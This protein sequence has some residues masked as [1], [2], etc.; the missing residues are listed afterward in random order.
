MTA[1]AP[2]QVQPGSL[3]GLPGI[4]RALENKEA[5]DGI[6]ATL[7]QATSTP[8]N[9]M[10]PFK[11]T[12]V[13][14]GWEFQ[15]TFATTWTAGTQTLNT[16]PYFPY[17]IV[18][19][20]Q[21]TM[22]NQ[23]NSIVAQSGIDLA[24][25]QVIRPQR[26]TDYKNALYTNKDG[27]A[28]YTPQGL[29]PSA[30]NYTTASTSITMRM[31]VPGG[32]WFDAFYPL[33]GDGSILSGPVRAFV[34]P[35][36][37]AGTARIVQP[38]ITYN[39][40]LGTTLDNAPVVATGTLTTPATFTGSSTL[41]LKRRGWYQPQG[42]GDSPAIYNW[43]Y[44]RQAKPYSLSGLTTAYIP[45]P[46]NGQILSIFVRLF[47]PTLASNIGGPIPLA[48]V[49]E[50]DVIYGSGL[51]RF[52]DRPVDMQARFIAQHGTL[53]TNGVLAWDMA[54]DDFGRVTNAFALNTMNTSGVQVVLTFTGAQSSS[55]YAVV[56]VEALTYVEVG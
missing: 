54:L 42:V 13:I 7:A 1:A 56:G 38:Q 33:S 9:G 10:V 49:S 17:N 21:L 44:T 18:G 30:G 36:Y 28:M 6:T 8:Q 47:D 55:A 37:M 29:L 12:D 51:Y 35:Q 43:Q 16:S 2:A 15:W 40:G 19:P 41:N 3:F 48:N 52:Q 50:C 5:N 39:P 46:L 4:T 53:I 20:F 27:V 25:W 26:Q 32:I 34:S 31:E 24:L 23:F 11:Q 45:I 22:Q 14:Q